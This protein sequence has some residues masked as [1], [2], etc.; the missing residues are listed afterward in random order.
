MGSLGATQ[1]VDWLAHTSPKVLGR[2]LTLSFTWWWRLEQTGSFEVGALPGQLPGTG[3]SVATVGP[4]STGSLA[5]HMLFSVPMYA[6][7]L[8]V[9]ED[10]LVSGMYYSKI[11]TQHSVPMCSA[12][13][14]GRA[15]RIGSW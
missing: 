14:D 13:L 15:V 2:A 7:T 1:E 12:L 8:L 3:H 9:C 6:H 5:W 10:C 11:E 4:W